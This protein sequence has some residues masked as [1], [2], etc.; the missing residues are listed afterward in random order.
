M[1]PLKALG[2][3]FR[4]ST[5]ARSSQWAD[6]A[7]DDELAA[8]AERLEL[9]VHKDR[10]NLLACLRRYLEDDESVNPFAYSEIVDAVDDHYGGSPDDDDDDDVKNEDGPPAAKK[11]PRY[12]WKGAVEV[13]RTTKEVADL[14]DRIRATSSGVIGFD[15]EC[16]RL[17]ETLIMWPAMVQL[18]TPA[19]VGLIWLDKLPDHGRDALNEDAPLGAFL[20]DASVYKAGVGVQ[21]D[22]ATLE[23]F[24]RRLIV[25][26]LVDLNDDS[27]PPAT[28]AD[29]AALWLGKAMPKKKFFGRKDGKK[30]HWRADVLTRDMKRYAVDDAA[31]PLAIFIAKLSSKGSPQP[32]SP[33]SHK[34]SSPPP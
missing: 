33:Q 22:A 17:D 31:A 20:A 24:S 6:V 28:L 12:A 10:P 5:L 30:A 13:A 8:L 1:R 7:T 11:L 21:G 19:V 32:S 9:D 29:L 27:D 26:G 14:V 15:I 4:L 23:G 3:D 2:R 16:A 25:R 18:A 34:S